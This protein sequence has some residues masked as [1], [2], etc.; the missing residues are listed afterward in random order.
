MSKEVTTIIATDCGSTTT[1]AIL[2]EKVGDEYRQL[3]RGEA[4]TTVEAPFEDV[5]RGVLN[6]IMELE[7]L[8]TQYY[9]RDEMK[10]S[11]YYNK[12]RKFV[13]KGQILRP[14]RDNNGVEE[15]CDIYIST[16]SAGGGLQM[17]VFGVVKAMTAESAQRAALGAGAIVMDTL[18][19]NDGRLPHEKIERIRSLRPDMILIAG[20]TDSA[21][22]KHVI[23]MSELVKSAR[24]TPRL[25]IG[26]Q[27]P[28]IYAGNKRAQNEILEILNDSTALSIVDNLRPELERENLRPASDKIHDLFMEH[29]MQQA[30]GYDKLMT[31]TDA[32]IMPTPG[33]VGLII[34]KI[35]E[36]DDIN[37]VGVDIGGA[38]T[39]VF[40]VFKLEAQ[41]GTKVQ[42]F[43]RTVSANLGM[44]YSISN[45][46]LEAG[47]DNIM[48]WV[49]FETD[50]HELRNRIG[51]KM[52]R[53]TTIPQTKEDLDIEQAI[54]REALR[55][56]FIQH[57]DFAV[58]LKG[59]QQQKGI[60]EAFDDASSSDT[61]VKMRDLNLIVGSGGVLSHAPLR[62]QSA[63]M[64]LDAFL[65]EGIT[66]LAVDSIFMMPQLGVLSDVDRPG[67]AQA[68][69]EVFDKDC[70]IHLAATICPVGLAKEGKDVVRVKADLPN[71]TKLDQWFKANEVIRFDFERGI[72]VDFEIEPAKGFDVGAGKNKKVVTKLSGGVVGL[73]IDTRGRPFNFSKDFKGRVEM[74][75][76]W[77]IS[78]TYVPKS[79]KDGV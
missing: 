72:E 55:L 79:N 7:E 48:R 25:G 76:K 64:M 56:S 66:N 44:S 23:S 11:K 62:S 9:A 6:A 21:K 50:E 12:P 49:P 78:K 19:I 2:I 4:P 54:C 45:V 46:L 53:P 39:D 1:K 38:T 63:H 75:D 15:G 68:A 52:I 58:G 13:E 51:N 30:P 16:S 10:S 5:T 33:A 47:I 18:S 8:A 73:I 36:R 42:K 14:K 61:I 67:C 20:E 74:L 77:N 65:P 28:V 40:S 37:V 60:A 41:D 35:G 71:G 70:L 29:V 26:F 32:P 24:P 59:V 3:V 34:Q 57:K 22:P 17:M 43:N 27:L 31:W 69:T